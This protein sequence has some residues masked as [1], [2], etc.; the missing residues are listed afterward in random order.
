MTDEKRVASKSIEELVAEFKS[1]VEQANAIRQQ[2]KE[3]ARQV[4]A[5]AGGGPIAGK[6]SHEIDVP[7]EG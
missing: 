1:L 6:S 4:E 7:P 2:M 5:R 3:L